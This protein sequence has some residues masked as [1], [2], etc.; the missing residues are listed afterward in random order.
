MNDTQFWASCQR[1]DAQDAKAKLSHRG[2][3]ADAVTLRV[4]RFHLWSVLT[5][6][7][8]LSKVAGPLSQ[9]AKLKSLKPQN[10]QNTKI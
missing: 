10:S 8:G 2:I 7:P 6:A 3:V 1:L 4:S 9:P 5:G